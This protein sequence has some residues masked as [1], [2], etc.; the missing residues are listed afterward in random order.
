MKSQNVSALF[1]LSL[2]FTALH[3]SA[4]AQDEVIS[5]VRVAFKG[6]NSKEVARFFN[7]TLE[8]I[9]QPESVELDNASNAQAEQVLKNFFEKY[10]VKEFSWDG[11][12]GASPAGGVYR[13]GTYEGNGGKFTVF[14]V[15]KQSG[16]KYMIDRLWIQ[17]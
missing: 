17:K 2:I 1:T 10:P 14:M 15:L 5:S 8:L 12:Q 11:H 6:N 9:I 13:T 3:L 16:G 4:F 7:N